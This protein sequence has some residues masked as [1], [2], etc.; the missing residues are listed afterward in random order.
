MA[1]IINQDLYTVTKQRVKNRQ[2]KINL[3]NYSYQIVDEITGNVVSGTISVDANNDQRRS[4][5]I[6]LVVDDR[7]EFE[8]KSGG[9]IWLDKYIQIFASEFNF[10]TQEWQWVNLGIYIINTPTWVYDASTNAL[11]LKVQI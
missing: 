3:L 5:N 11:S 1:L 4:C 8:I 9:K 6:T 10:L 7:N 2:I